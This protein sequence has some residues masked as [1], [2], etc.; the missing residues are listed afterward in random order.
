[1]AVLQGSKLF[2][3]GFDLSPERAVA[4]GFGLIDVVVVTSDSPATQREVDG[5]IENVRLVSSQHQACENI[6]AAILRTVDQH[7]VNGFHEEP[8]HEI[9]VVRSLVR[10]VLAV[11]AL[12][13]FH[14]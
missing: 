3:A 9:D 7:L 6:S 13:R 11:G 1:M 14:L 5:T 10:P 4:Y 12:H 8:E 2:L